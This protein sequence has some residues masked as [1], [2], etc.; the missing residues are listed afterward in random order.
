MSTV[1]VRLGALAASFLLGL[2]AC[3]GASEGEGS[4]IVRGLDREQSRV[5]IEHGEIPGLMKAMTMTFD[6]APSELLEG[7]DVGD[8]VTFDLRYAE[9]RYTVVGIEER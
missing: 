6:V 4:G 7:V 8:A 3:G 9:G 1:P 2:A 5:T